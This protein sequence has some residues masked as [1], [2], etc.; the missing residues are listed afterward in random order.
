ME[1][2]KWVDMELELS[3]KHEEIIMRREALLRGTECYFSSEDLQAS[4]FIVD[5]RKAEERNENLMRNINESL[6]N[7]RRDR[8]TNSPGFETITKNYWSMVKS[9]F[10]VWYE[11]YTKESDRTFKHSS[12]PFS[13][14]NDQTVPKASH[15][16]PSNTN[17]Q[18]DTSIGPNERSDDE[19]PSTSVPP[20]D[21]DFIT[22]E[23]A[24]QEISVKAAAT[25][26][27]NSSLN[28]SGKVAKKE[29]RVHYNEEQLSA[30][31]RKPIRK[32]KS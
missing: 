6:T 19:L 15:Q 10:P 2:K 23:D 12:K 22:G 32:P 29:K 18:T 1:L 30:A 28:S 4:S 31:A 9:I 7:I 17:K 16:S 25:L 8:N 21:L 26:E 24:S 13:D 27:T 14:G 3:R 20:L 5:I 11:Q